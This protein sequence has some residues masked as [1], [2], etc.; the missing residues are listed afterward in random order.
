MKMWQRRTGLAALV[1]V[2]FSGWLAVASGQQKAATTQQANADALLGAA[3]YQEQIEGKLEAAVASYRKVLAAAD[4]TREQKA[5]AQ[6]RIGA[7]YERLGFGEA[8]K[9]Y[10][11]VVANYAD[12]VEFAAQAKARLAALAGPA[13]R[14][15]SPV[16]RQI[17]VTSEG[18]AWNR[19]SPDGRSVA[20]IDD[21]TG[22]LVIR[23][24]ATGQTRRLTAIPKDRWRKDYAS[25]PIWSSDGRQIAYLWYP[26]SPPA[27][28]RIADVADGTSKIV[29]MDARFALFQPQDWSPDGRRVLA[30]VSD[31]LPKIRSLHL[32]WVATSGGTVQLLASASK[33]ARLGSAF[34]APDGAWIV[35][36]IMEDDAGVSILAAAGGPPRT[37]IPFTPSDSLVGWNADGTHVLFISRERGSDDLMAVRVVDGQAV[38]QPFLIRTLPGF[39]SLGVS[40]GGA[41][42]YRSIQGATS[43]VYRASFDATSGRVGPPS[44]VDVSTGHE[45]GS[46]SWSPEGRRLAYVSWPNGQLSKTLSIWSAENGQTR[47]FSLPFKAARWG[48]RVNPW[49]ADGRWV[50]VSGQ[51][52]ASLTGLFRINTESGVAEEVLP[53]SSGVF[54]GGDISRN[55]YTTLLGWSPDARVVYKNVLTW[56]GSGV[57]AH[58]AI[59]EHRVADHAERE[60]FNSGSGRWRVGGFAASPDGSQLAFTVNEFTARQL[61]VMVMPAAGGPAKT[62]ATLPTQFDG[63][64]RWTHDGR[65]VVIAERRDV[66]GGERLLC[67]V[68]TGVVTK[69]TLAAEVVSEICLSPDGKEIAYVG[70][71]LAKDEGVWML[72]NFLPKPKAPTPPA[73]T[74][75]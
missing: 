61:M 32:A 59:V 75:Q 62:V 17:W 9:A 67:D 63:V 51:D 58:A 48:W 73:K 1:T 68:T 52:E 47:S 64:V 56:A 57:V 28:F 55:P 21:G 3:Q 38:G 65:S 50:Y 46:V 18:V 74:R 15:G 37:L 35:S 2:A 10:E 20:G 45:K 69:L 7:C 29:P 33:G 19:I 6:F 25:S 5:R 36:R 26:G 12:Q 66:S 60:L 4:A 70:G 72:E 16:I 27:E 34:L 41:L 44:R 8:R 13:G 49:S 11:A 71:A 14:S 24:L 22:D 39:S 42:L 30:I 54:P 23:S 53:P 40:R 43:N 31:A